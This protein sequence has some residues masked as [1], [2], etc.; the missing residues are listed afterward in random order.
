MEAT[1][2]VTVAAYYHEPA[3]EVNSPIKPY[4]KGAEDSDDEISFIQFQ[5]S[6]RPSSKYG[7][8]PPNKIIKIE[9]VPVPKLSFNHF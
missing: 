7:S 6:Q 4:V 8:P 2:K 3:E 5:K 9:P 1:R